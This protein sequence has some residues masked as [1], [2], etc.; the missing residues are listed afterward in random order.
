MQQ[1]HSASTQSKVEIKDLLP[2]EF[3]FSQDD[4][5]YLSKKL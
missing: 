3:K 2:K 5:D 4:I 1:F